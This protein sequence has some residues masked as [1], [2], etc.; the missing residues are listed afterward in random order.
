MAQDVPPVGALALVL[1]PGEGQRVGN[2]KNGPTP[3]V[4]VQWSIAGSSSSTT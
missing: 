1:E 4:R 2:R 3:I